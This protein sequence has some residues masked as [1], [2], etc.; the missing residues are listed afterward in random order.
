MI[1]ASSLTWKM[2]KRSESKLQTKVIIHGWRGS[3]DSE[4]N[5]LIKDAWMA[6]EQCQVIAFT[7]SAAKNNFYLWPRLQVTAVGNEIG[8][9][10]E[11]LGEKEVTDLKS[12]EII[13]HSLE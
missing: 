13:V 9:I 6:I 5:S 4:L 1:Q 8:N 2:R 11:D 7:W 10:M 12:T 3:E